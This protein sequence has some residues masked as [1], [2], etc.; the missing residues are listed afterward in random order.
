[1]AR[2]K[3]ARRGAG[4]SSTGTG[5]ELRIIGGD[6]RSRKL[7]F[8]DAG[9]VRPTP[10]RTR[11]TLFNWLAMHLPGS[12]CLD[13]FSGSGALGLE[14]LSRGAA[15]ATLVDHTPALANAL[16]D[17]LRVLGC[18]TGQVVCRDVSDYLRT[19]PEAPFDILFMDPPFRQGWL[20]QLL[21]LIEANGWLKPGGWLYVEHESEL[22]TLPVP[23][24]WQLHREKTAG[25]VCYKLF[26]LPVTDDSPTSLTD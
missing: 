3:P 8:P 22:N 16:K 19:R 17:N 1:M 25:Q 14:A 7:R 2:R 20:D 6:W 10:A 15:S 9:G 24:G 26:R 4:R 5:G 18:T 11:E 21:P 12:H 13:L 23:A